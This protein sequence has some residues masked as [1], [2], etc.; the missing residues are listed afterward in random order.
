MENA[1][2]NGTQKGVWGVVSGT[3]AAPVEDAD[4]KVKERYA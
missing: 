1:V 4:D 3:E 2:Y